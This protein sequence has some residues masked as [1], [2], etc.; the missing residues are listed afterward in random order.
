[1]GGDG[2]G[3]PPTPG[4]LKPA[5]GGPA[6]A[7][8]LEVL[9]RTYWKPVYLFIRTVWK[10]SNE[11]AKDL[12]QQF[13]VHLMNSQ[14]VERYRP[15][16]ASFRAYIKTC[17]RNF[18]ADEHRRRESLKSGGDRA[19]VPLDAVDPPVEQD[20]DRVWVQSV[21]EAA[22]DAV[23]AEVA[24]DRP[25][26]WA[27]FEAYDLSESTASYAELGAQHGMSEADVRNALAYVRGRL[28]DAVVR[29]VRESVSDPEQLAEELGQLGL[30]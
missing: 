5:A 30:L 1:M 26:H 3:F 13:F 2:R 20:F 12:A 7:D 8:A 6:W 14:A 21:V 24:P 16:R 17:L 9:S 15:S 23:K 10:C 18:L 28:R 25:A 19:T 11:D 4:A 29:Q 27:V 22:I